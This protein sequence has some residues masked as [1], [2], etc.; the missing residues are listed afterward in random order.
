MTDKKEI[1]CEYCTVRSNE[2]KCKALEIEFH[3]CLNILEQKK[4][5]IYKLKQQLQEKEKECEE[6]KQWKKDAENLFKTQTD[7]AD[8]I[9]S[10]YKQA[11]EPF[12]DDYFKNL[13][14]KTIAELAK[15][16]IRLTTENRKFE[17][18]L[19]EI[20]DI[21]DDYNRVEKTSQYYR[22][23][24]DEIQNITNKAKGGV[25]GNT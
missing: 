17:D 9:I 22:D 13:D 25:N 6:L 20:E 21:A 19:D 14:T 5:P 11:L 7:N 12:K 4:C 16:S 18:V 3:N 8:K 15:K 24:F 10:R 23:G 2:N 1:Q